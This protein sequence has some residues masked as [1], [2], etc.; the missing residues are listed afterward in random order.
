[1]PV[2][3][4][5]I[6]LISEEKKNNFSCMYLVFAAAAAAHRAA[7]LQLRNFAHAQIDCPDMGATAAVALERKTPFDAR[8]RAGC[9]GFNGAHTRHLLHLS[10]KSLCIV[11]SLSGRTLRK[12]QK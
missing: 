5:R 4:E 10:D 2:H 1:M 12:I 6:V 8:G 3:P 11:R 7:N 9:M